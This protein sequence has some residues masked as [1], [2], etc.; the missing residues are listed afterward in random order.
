MKQSIALFENLPS[1]ADVIVVGA[2]LAGYCAALEAADSGARVVLLEK[3]PA[4][5]GSS[6]LS[7]GFMAF[8]G[9]PLQAAAGIH[10]DDALLFQDLRAVGG[11]EA[12][13][14]L[15]EVYV[16]E[17]RALYDWLVERGVKFLAL[18]RSA[19][20]SVARSHQTDPQSLLDTLARQLAGHAN[21]VMV[22]KA[23]LHSLLRHE[24]DGPVTGVM[25]VVDG[26]KRTIACKGGIVLASGGFS[27]SESLLSLFAPA[28]ASAVRIGGAGNTGDGLRQA[29]KLGAGMRDMAQIRGTFGTHPACT[30]E[31]HEILLAYYLG[32]IIVNQQGKRF[33]DESRPYKQLG[34]ACL[35]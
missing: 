11:K 7:G 13:Q 9:T 10:D 23:A 30:S 5:G 32:A 8:A 33:V 24:V 25:V 1:S 22:T 18:E 31:K 16:R 35:Q 27:R 17:Q 4:A 12:D 14:A 20:Q 28:Q 6:V 34:D 3:Q 19:G 15:L 2:G 26:E 21:A 29:W